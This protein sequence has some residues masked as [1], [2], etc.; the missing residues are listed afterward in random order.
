MPKQALPTDSNFHHSQRHTSPATPEPI[1][2]RSCSELKVE[3]IVAQLLLQRGVST[4]EE[5][6][7]FFRPKLDQLHDQL[8][9]DDNPQTQA[10]L[11]DL[12]KIYFDFV[13]LTV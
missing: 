12:R 8:S 10:N 1:L 11:N 5:A 2:D 4:F 3:P 6:E 7:E 9:L 13:L